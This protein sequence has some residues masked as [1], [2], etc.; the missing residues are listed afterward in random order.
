MDADRAPGK[1]AVCPRCGSP[2]Q[3]GDSCDRCG[4]HYSPTDLIDPVSTLSGAAPELRSAAHLF[5]NIERLH[6]FLEE[7][8]QQGD[9]LQKGR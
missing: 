8:T 3:Y 1:D 2:D 7:W 4:A 6:G 5:V 9:H